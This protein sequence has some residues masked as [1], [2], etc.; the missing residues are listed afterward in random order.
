MASPPIPSQKPNMQ[1]FID[2]DDVETFMLTNNQLYDTRE[3]PTNIQAMPDMYGAKY[4][5]Q[6]EALMQLINGANK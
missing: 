1:G 2:P 6:L 4:R 5:E 3:A